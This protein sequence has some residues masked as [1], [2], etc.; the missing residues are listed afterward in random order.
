VISQGHQY[1]KMIPAETITKVMNGRSPKLL[2]DIHQV[3][4]VNK[5]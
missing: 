4:D 3:S 1:E 5:D 2:M